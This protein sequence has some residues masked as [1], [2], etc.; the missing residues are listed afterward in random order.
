MTNNKDFL[1]KFIAKKRL[2]DYGTKKSERVKNKVTHNLENCIL[3]REK[4][5]FSYENCVT[6]RG[7]IAN[8]TAKKLMKLWNVEC[9]HQLY[10]KDGE[11][12][13]VLNSFPGAL[14]D[15]N[16]YVI[17][18]TE[19]DFNRCKYLSV[20][21]EASKGKGQVNVIGIHPQ[22]ISKIKGYIQMKFENGKWKKQK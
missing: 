10:N 6:C 4:L 21:R 13:H 15:A 19:D 2:A 1:K 11:W 14:F 3:C 8:I 7:P 20:N 9:S 5:D 16:G 22:S 17:F 18:E 12:Y